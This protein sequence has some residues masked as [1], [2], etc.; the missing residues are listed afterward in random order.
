MF[1]AT[2]Y[3]GEIYLVRTLQNN[4]IIDRSQSLVQVASDIDVYM[5]KSNAVACSVLPEYIAAG[6]MPAFRWRIL[7]DSCG[8][9]LYHYQA[10]MTCEFYNTMPKSLLT[11]MLSAENTLFVKK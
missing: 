1:D 5:R 3:T 6:I 7:R 4:K 2:V 9:E 8:R 10:S 11:L